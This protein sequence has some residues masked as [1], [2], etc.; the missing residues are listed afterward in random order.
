[1]TEHQ[2]SLL[3]ETNPRVKVFTYHERRFVLVDV[4]ENECSVGLLTELDCTVAENSPKEE[5]KLAPKNRSIT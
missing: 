5:L 2:A 3:N 1:M 4:D